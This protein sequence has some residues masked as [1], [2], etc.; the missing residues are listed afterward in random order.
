MMTIPECRDELRA[1]IRKLREIERNMYRRPAARRARREHDVMTAA[2]ARRIRAFAKEH[3]RMSYRRIGE[4]FNVG[5]G[6][7]SEAIRG[8]RKS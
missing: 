6:R 3:P 5:I 2:L 4:R 8:R 7:V 1:V